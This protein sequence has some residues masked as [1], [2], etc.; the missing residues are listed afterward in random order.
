M[1]WS[2]PDISNQ[3]RVS[4]CDMLSGGNRT[5]SWNADNQPISITGTDGGVETYAYDVSVSLRQGNRGVRVER[6]AFL[7]RLG[8]GG[9]G[10][11]LP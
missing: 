2:K 7:P 5:Y 10:Q 9:R 11:P 1:G 4:S 6:A 3:F 8:E